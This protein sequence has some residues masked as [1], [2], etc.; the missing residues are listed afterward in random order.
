MSADWLLSGSALSFWPKPGCS[1]ATTH[2]AFAQELTEKYPDVNVDSNPIWIQ[3]GNIYTSA[4]VT[5]GIDLALK[6]VE[7]DDGAAVA[8]QVARG[9]VVF[10][11]RPG[12]PGS[13]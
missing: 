4:G 12:G 8:L 2:W 9:F 10:L 1:V 3:G 5:A 11:R 13:I 6:M 7:E